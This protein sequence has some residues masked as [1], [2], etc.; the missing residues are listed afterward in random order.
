[1]TPSGDIFLVSGPTREPALTTLDVEGSLGTNEVQ[2]TRK[3]ETGQEN[4]SV[5]G[6]AC[7]AII[8]LTYLRFWRE[9]VGQLR[10][11]HTGDHISSGRSRPYPSVKH[12]AKPHGLRLARLTVRAVSWRQLANSKYRLWD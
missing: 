1:M 9:N 5:A 11:L 2:W 6:E 8:M 10:V 7:V 4:L 3:V 12:G